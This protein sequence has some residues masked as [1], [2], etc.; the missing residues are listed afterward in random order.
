MEHP[1]CPPGLGLNGFWLFPKIMSTLKGRR[2]QDF[3]TSI[4]V[5]KFESRKTASESWHR[6][7]QRQIYKLA[8][9][10]DLPSELV[11]SCNE[12]LRI[13]PKKKKCED[14]TESYSTTGFRKTFPTDAASLG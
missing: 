1:S 13:S 10:R 11:M 7:R 5:L 12:M 2:F 8:M 14:E 6:E 9:L 3:M 4:P